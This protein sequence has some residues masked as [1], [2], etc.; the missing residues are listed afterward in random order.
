VVVLIPGDGISIGGK[1]KLKQEN[2]EERDHPESD[3][4]AA[5]WAERMGTS[6]LRQQSSRRQL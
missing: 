2:R 1:S 3:L 5:G 4:I 6:S